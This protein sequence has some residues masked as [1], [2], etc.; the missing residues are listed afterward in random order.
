MSVLADCIN[1]YRLKKEYLHPELRLEVM[2]MIES[3]KIIT[4]SSAGNIARIASLSCKSCIFHNENCMINITFIIFKS[5]EIGKFIGFSK[6]RPG[7][8]MVF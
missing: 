2:D 8:R 4:K 1:S 5:I 3:G 7:M 6:L